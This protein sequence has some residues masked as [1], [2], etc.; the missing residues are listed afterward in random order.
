MGGNKP[1]YLNPLII[2]ML[3][4]YFLEVKQKLVLIDI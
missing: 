2:K 3:E 1:Y 4:T